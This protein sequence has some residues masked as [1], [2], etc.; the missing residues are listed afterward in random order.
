MGG[1]GGGAG[2]GSGGAGSGLGQGE[3]GDY[4]GPGYG[5][6]G[7]GG[8]GYGYG[9][10]GSDYGG[11]GYAGD[12]GGAGDVGTFGVPGVTTGPLD[13][14]TPY[15]VD[16]ITGVPTPVTSIYGTRSTNPLTTVDPGIDPLDPNPNPIDFSNPFDSRFGG[17]ISNPDQTISSAPGVDPLGIGFDPN[18]TGPSPDVG[19][20]ASPGGP[21]TLGGLSDTGVTGANSPTNLSFPF[22]DLFYQPTNLPPNVQIPIGSY[23]DPNARAVLPEMGFDN[24]PTHP[25]YVMASGGQAAGSWVPSWAVSAEDRQGTVAFPYTGSPSSPG[26]LGGAGA[27]V[28]WYGP[29][30]SFNY[31]A[32]EHTPTGVTPVDPRG[33]DRPASAYDY[34]YQAPAPPPPQPAYYGEPTPQPGTYDQGPSGGGSY[35]PTAEAP[36]PPPA[37]MQYA[38][39]DPY[40]YDPFASYLAGSMAG[41]GGGYYGGPGG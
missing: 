17:W 28:A 4:G 26:D 25:G 18:Q 40:A 14:N 12:A 20:T 37:P 29:D 30:G 7:Y 33:A 27:N 32:P 38:A 31:T 11:V 19:T 3:A 24:K 22:G 21:S 39:P 15:V 5:Y 23:Y 34:S 6:A 2:A 10:A 35:Y 41:P 16:P 13:P 9:Q 1:D 8:Y 36:A